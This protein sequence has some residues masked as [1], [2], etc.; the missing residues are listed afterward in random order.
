M[1]FFW[2]CRVVLERGQ[3]SLSFF[4]AP[5]KLGAVFVL[6]A[7]DVAAPFNFYT[8][9]CSGVQEPLI[10]TEVLKSMAGW[11]KTARNLPTR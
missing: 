6:L 4:A 8:G 5:S 3:F 7:R 9:V 2:L 11:L 10:C 1:Q